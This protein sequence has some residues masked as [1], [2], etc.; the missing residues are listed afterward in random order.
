MLYLAGGAA[1]AILVIWIIVAAFQER[2][3]RVAI[4]QIAVG[5]VR[6][7][8]FEDFA[9]VRGL[10]VPLAVHY[11]TSDAGGV[12][13]KVFVEDGTVVAAN[14]PLMQLANTALELQVASRE[15]DT[16]GQISNL[17][18]A[19]LQ[20][21]ETQFRYKHDLLD[22]EHQLVS[23]KAT[24]ERDNRLMKAGAIAGAV[25][26]SD[27]D[28]LIYLQKQRKM[29]IAT[30]DLEE[31]LRSGQLLQIKETLERLQKSISAARASLDALTI[32]APVAG[33][34]TALDAQIGQAKPAG[35][36]FGQID[37]QNEFKLTA[38][39]D[40]YYVGRLT[41]GR[42]ARFDIEGQSF[43]AKI[44]KIYPQVKDGGF[45]VDLAFA[46]RGPKAVHGGQ[47]V[48]LKISLGGKVKALV[49]PNGP[50]YQDTGGN[51]V[52]VLGPD[53]SYATR[54]NVRL[55]RRNP[56]NI[57][58]LDGLA[59]GERVILSSYGDFKEVNRIEF[60]GAT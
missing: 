22:L 12:V 43:A 29:T 40:E 14:Q 33:E 5:T 28:N 18:N 24:V 1:A 50:F 8:P 35:A 54:R 41:I 13:Q 42:T 56:Q 26:E 7:G 47:T 39:V 55:G 15:A 36:V 10:V 48:D 16:A 23:T 21:D 51:W 37:S 2:V 49:L 9:A 20:L 59:P 30:R 25:L 46:G 19:E 44:I 4:D 57:E 6:E 52:Y 32:R 60:D 38:E 3:Y 58:V 31:K 34:L 11:L 17:Q 27:R 53:G 45:K